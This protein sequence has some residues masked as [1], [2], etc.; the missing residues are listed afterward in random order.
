MWRTV[1]VAALGLGLTMASGVIAL[2]QDGYGYPDRDRNGYP[3]RGGY[4]YY[5]RDD[6]GWGRQ[7]F[8][9]ARDIGFQDGARVGRE[10]FF[11]CKPYDPYPRGRYSNSDHG[12]R[13]E[14]GDRY[15]YRELY[16]RSYQAGYRSAFGRY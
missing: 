6:Y 9:V 10:D 3:D 1:R 5:D 2:A 12:F 7:G 8:H 14:Y 15:R 16:S 13:R 11:R 4:G